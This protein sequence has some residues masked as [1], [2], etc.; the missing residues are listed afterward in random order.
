LLR[1]QRYAPTVIIDGSHIPREAAL[2]FFSDPIAGRCHLHLQGHLSVTIFSRCY[3]EE[4]H[5]AGLKIIQVLRIPSPN[6]EEHA[7][8][9]AWSGG[10]LRRGLGCPDALERDADEVA[11]VRLSH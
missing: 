9:D 1:M 2:Q 3:R 6:L 7:S 8:L 5:L 11:T 10:L 4:S